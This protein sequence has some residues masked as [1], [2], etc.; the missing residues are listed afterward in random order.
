MK[1][2]MYNGFEVNKTLISKRQL[3]AETAK[4]LGTR[5]TID[6]VKN[7]YKALQDTASK[8]LR[9]ANEYN[10]VS[11]NFGYGLSITSTIREIN[12]YPRMWLKAKISR[13]FN[14]HIINEYEN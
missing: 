4:S 13:Y 9:T 14:R 7:V 6:D 8:H 11:V 10:V 3:L 1:T 12:N 5:F 2:K